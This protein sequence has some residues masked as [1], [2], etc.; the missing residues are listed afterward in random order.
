M[1]NK[2]GFTII[3]LIVVIAIIAVLSSIVMVGVNN[4]RAKARDARR[5]SDL[6]NIR[7]ALE[8]YFV[9]NGF[10]PP[11]GCG[12]D[13]NGYFVSYD[14]SSWQT[15]ENYLK[16][17]ISS[18]PKDPVNSACAP[19]GDDCYSYTYGNVGRYIYA[20]QYDLTGQ[21]EIKNNP[22]ACQFKGYKFYFDNYYG[23]CAQSGG[24]YSNYLYETSP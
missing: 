16:P 8:M 6:R 14:P 10:Y 21:F 7:K 12:Y 20:N 24:G 19:W 11:S 1:N 22:L 15:L 13:C 5:V 2:R 17:Y 3:E 23:W 4:F 18:L 9:D